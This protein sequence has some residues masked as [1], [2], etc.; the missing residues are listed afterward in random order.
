[1]SGPSTLAF[2]FTRR[3]GGGGG[4]VEWKNQSDKSL[5]IEEKEG[6]ERGEQHNASERA[7]RTS[8]Q[9]SERERENEKQVARLTFFLEF[10][11]VPL[12][13][14]GLGRGQQ[15]NSTKRE[16]TTKRFTQVVQL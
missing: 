14:T 9:E 8:Q 1:M 15:L 16:H 11:V 4:D 13:L 7:K 10:G 2:P 6:E 12:A 3:K 5:P